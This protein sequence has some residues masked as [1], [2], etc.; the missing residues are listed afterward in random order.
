MA[1]ILSSCSSTST[2]TVQDKPKYVGQTLGQL[3]NI[4]IDLD[5]EIS[6]NAS[7][8]ESLQN[9]EKAAENFEDT[10]E[11]LTSMREMADLAVASAEIDIDYI[12][13]DRL[14]DDSPSTK[15]AP[16]DF[17]KLLFEKEDKNYR[18][19]IDLYQQ[20]I[21]MSQDESA[22]MESYYNLAKSYDFIGETE[23]SIETLHK[24]LSEYP[25]NPFISEANFRL[26]EY[27]FNDQDF[28][29]AAEFFVKVVKDNSNTLYTNHAYYKKAWCEYNLAELD[30]ALDDFFTLYETMLASNKSKSNERLLEEASRGISLTFFYK[31]G[32]NSI[33]EYF[34]KVG[35]KQYESDIYLNL[36][37]FYIAKE[38]YQDAAK[39]YKNYIV[40][41]PESEK[42][43][44]FSQAQIDLFQKMGDISKILQAKQEF[45]TAFGKDSTYWTKYP[46]RREGYHKMLSTNLVDLAQYHHAS[47]QKT[48]TTS[49]FIQANTW[50]KSFLDIAND[51]NE[52]TSTIRH[53][54]AE[55]L[56]AVKDLP[57]AIEQFQIL[58]YDAKDYDKKDEAAYTA[59]VARD[60]LIDATPQ[61]QQKAL[62]IIK[63]QEQL[64]FA[65]AFATHKDVNIVLANAVKTS[66]AAHPL[67]Q[68]ITIAEKLQSSPSA[69]A[70]QKLYALET[71]A[72]ANFDLKRYATS[73]QQYAKLLTSTITPEQKTAYIDR[74]SRSIYRQAEALKAEDKLNEAADKLLQI[75]EY[76]TTE[77]APVALFDAG[78]IYLKQ[79]NWTQSITVFTRLRQDHPNHALNDTVP[80]KLAIAYE[81]NQRID[82]A[83]AEYETI[84]QA[85]LNIDNAL[86]QAALFKAAGYYEKQELFTD[87]I[88]AYQRYIQLP[89]LNVTQQAEGIHKLA[90]NN[91]ALENASEYKRWLDELVVLHKNAG[92]SATERTAFLAADAGFKL[93]A[94]HFERFRQAKITY[95]LKQSIGVKKD[96]MVN[97]ITLYKEV[98][99]TR[100][101]KYNTAARHRIG[102]IYHIFAKDLIDSE[103]PAGL[104]ELE[105][106]QYEILL[107][108]EALPLED[109]AIKFYQSNTKLALDGIYDKWVRSSYKELAN[110]IP[111]KYAKYEQAE[112]IVRIV[113]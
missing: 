106:E 91:K 3:S 109:D 98:L 67:T 75:A 84:A 52:N 73:E 110:I 113:N 90:E 95:P 48:N 65:D 16:E 42:A 100:V 80:D 36:G 25:E 20:I 108:D 15:E 63:I 2:K 97:A 60:D 105:L 102:N 70:E 33:V 38:R 13:D 31:D 22:K 5:S 72:N 62:Q 23:Q 71:I 81:N 46:E 107:E 55:S 69:N 77:I 103:R 29:Y 61:A 40:Q 87:S 24:L 56:Y 41:N 17:E 57:T 79:E 9:F 8:E 94:P 111:A 74:L 14:S 12:T 89:D 47:A 1:A 11:K 85:S 6:E 104:S 86:A 83:A 88:R 101:K 112:S 18:I 96:Y 50:Y 92:S 4:S 66:L 26:G 78:D 10:T 64:K 43:P 53:Q 51:T 39:T 44:E 59:L 21:S 99:E 35:S 93:A 49:D 68:T 37:D 45:A 76:K 32:V 19:A 54:Y 58:A 34:N 82:L 27:Y 28:E 30:N 7:F